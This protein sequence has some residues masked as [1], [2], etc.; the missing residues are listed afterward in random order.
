VSHHRFFVGHVLDALRT[1]PDESVH[2]IVTSPPYFGLRDYGLPPVSWPEVEYS[3]MPGLPPV[4]VPAWEG[5]LGLEPTPEMYV[6]HLVLVFREVK[7][8]LR[9]DGTFWLNLGD[10]YAGSGGAHA[11]HHNNPGISNSWKRNGVPHYGKLG[12]PEK[13][14]PPKG[15]KA[16]DLIG[17]PWR[18]A[19]ALQADGWWLRSDCIWS[20]ANCLPESVRDRPTRSHE[21]VFLLTKSKQYF[22]DADAVKELGSSNSHGGTAYL[23]RKM[24]ALTSEGLA[25]QSGLYRAVPAGEGGR[26]RRSVWQ[27]NTE[28]FSGAHF[29]VFPRKL[30]E[31]CILAGTSPMACPSCGAPWAR[32]V[33][34]AEVPREAYLDRP[35]MQPGNN[36]AT[37][38]LKIP[39]SRR[40]LIVPLRTEGWRPTCSCPGND[41]S[42]RC[43][44]LDPFGGAGTTTLAA[45]S[46]ERD[47]IY[48]D[49]KQE[50][51]E[52]A[53]KRCGFLENKLFD[54]HSWELKSVS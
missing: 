14:T 49:Q 13:Y 38:W 26:N 15:L 51:A 34:R 40:H 27:I 50:Y 39:G 17:V 18:V 53:L 16:K 46:L 54:P 28:Q 9:K 52:M 5:Q 3:P 42:G 35:K 36:S 21:Y 20:K 19:F 7:R 2:C 47:S 24:V 45:M 4:R 41:G 37:S 10:S 43:I 12:M 22:Y 29:A 31:T 44:V 32:V 6:A 1:L 23:G 11:E 33:K 30:A 48:I 25:G 8:V